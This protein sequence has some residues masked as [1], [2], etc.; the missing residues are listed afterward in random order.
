M[1]WRALA[2]RANPEGYVASFTKRELQDAP[3]YDRDQLGS[4]HYGWGES[5]R[6]YFA[7]LGHP[8]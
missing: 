5:V 2:Y 7:G 8:V 1:P 4:T 3:S 6:R